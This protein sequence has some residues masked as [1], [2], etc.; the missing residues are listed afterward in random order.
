MGSAATYLDIADTSDFLLKL[1]LS[2]FFFATAAQ[3][4]FTPTGGGHNLQATNTDDEG[5]AKDE[6]RGRL[7]CP[8]ALYNLQV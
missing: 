2:P 8:Q 1:L 6:G 4:S 3:N 7:T 5:R